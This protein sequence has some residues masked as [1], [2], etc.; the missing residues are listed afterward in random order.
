MTEVTKKSSA[1][2]KVGE[3]N[4]RIFSENLGEIK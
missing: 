1:A 4:G 3:F 2:R